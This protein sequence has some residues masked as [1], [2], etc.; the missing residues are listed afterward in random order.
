MVGSAG[1]TNGHIR[2]HPDEFRIV[3]VGGKTYDRMSSAI[4]ICN[5]VGLLTEDRKSEGLMMQMDVAANICAASLGEIISGLFLDSRR[6]GEIAREEM[7]AF[8]VPR[9]VRRRGWSDF[10]AAI[11]KR[12]CSHAGCMRVKRCCFWTSQP[13]A[14][15]WRQGGN[16]PPDPEACG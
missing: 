4:S 14:S 10:P 15:R 5:G 8:R 12:F 11:S 7:N 16:L 3:T 1:W 9:R 13:A 2:R 6:E